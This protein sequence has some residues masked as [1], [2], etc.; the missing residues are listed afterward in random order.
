MQAAAA[1]LPSS[2]LT[3]S[4]V[5]PV[6]CS[7]QQ[8]FSK[9]QSAKADGAHTCAAH[10][11]L[12]CN[13]GVQLRGAPRYLA[14]SMMAPPDPAVLRPDE[15]L[16]LSSAYQLLRCARPS[17]DPNTGFMRQLHAF[18]QALHAVGSPAMG[19]SPL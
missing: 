13:S 19:C 4:L 15:G 9:L 14:Q 10:G 17:A 5:S 18:S 6:Q 2:S 12:H 8:L 16:S 3:S 11:H 1:Q 7:W